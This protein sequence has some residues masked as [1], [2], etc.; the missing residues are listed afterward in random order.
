[1][2]KGTGTMNEDANASTAKD[3]KM[4]SMSELVEKD[5]EELP[6]KELKKAL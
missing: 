2:T 3:Q 6:D 4:I 1:M 5:I